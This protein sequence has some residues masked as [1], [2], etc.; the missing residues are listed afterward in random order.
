LLV[1]N[2]GSNLSKDQFARRCPSAKLVGTGTIKGH[3]LTFTGRSNGWGGAVATIKPARGKSVLVAIYELRSPEDVRTLD[4]AEGFPA[5]YGCEEFTVWLDREGKS[6]KRIKAWTY[7]KRDQREGQP[8]TEYLKRIAQGYKDHGFNTQELALALCSLPA[9]AP[10]PAPKA[11]P[12]RRPGK[13]PRHPKK[14]KKGKGKKGTKPAPKPEPIAVEPTC[15]GKGCVPDLQ[16][17]GEIDCPWCDS[18]AG[19]DHCPECC[20]VALAEL[21]AIPAQRTLG[22]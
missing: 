4:R 22:W 18:P 11:K 19:V 2:Y 14:G 1:A 5:V 17:G 7:V 8:S 16:D 6:P 20:P 3:R 15:D 10:P 12:K 9:S 13:K 21:G